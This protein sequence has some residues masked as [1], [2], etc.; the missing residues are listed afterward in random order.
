MCLASIKKLVKFFRNLML[1]EQNE[2]RNR[3]LLIGYTNVNEPTTS[4]P[5][6][7]PHK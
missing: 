6:K 4:T 7:H 3:Y 2:L 1:G 5:H